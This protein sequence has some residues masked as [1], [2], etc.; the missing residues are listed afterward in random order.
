MEMNED[1]FCILT[2][3]MSGKAVCSAM[4]SVLFEGEKQN[5]TAKKYNITAQNL[6]QS[7][8]RLKA[9]WSLHLSLVYAG[10]K[11]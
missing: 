8:N 7:L 3:K 4:K 10:Q 6:G 1:Q 2:K 11:I 9:R 5:A